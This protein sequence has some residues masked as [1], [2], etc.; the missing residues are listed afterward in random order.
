M[1]R[2]DLTLCAGDSVRECWKRAHRSIQRQ[3]RKAFPGARRGFWGDSAS[4]GSVLGLIGDERFVS[5]GIHQRFQFRGIGKAHLDEPS[6]VVG[7]GIYFF[8]H[9]M[10]VAVGLNDFS[11]NRRIN[12][13]Y[14]FY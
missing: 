6:G 3:W 1:A 5:G 14:R 7:I 11:G 8:W 9:V 10:K 2:A 4:G 12:V 13:L